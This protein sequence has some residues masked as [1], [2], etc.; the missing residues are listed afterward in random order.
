MVVKC[1][2][3]SLE[4]IKG[5]NF[6]RHFALFYI[7]A[8]LMN[9][10]RIKEALSYINYGRF[11]DMT[12]LTSTLAEKDHKQKMFELN[13][14]RITSECLTA[15]GYF[16]KAKRVCRSIEFCKLNSSEPADVKVQYRKILAEIRDATVIFDYNVLR[17]F[18]ENET[19][20]IM[21]ENFTQLLFVG[22]VCQL[23]CD[24][25]K[26]L[27]LY[28]QY[29]R[30][31]TLPLEIYH[32]IR[33]V[34]NKN[35]RFF[36]STNTKSDKSYFNTPLGRSLINTIHINL[37]NNFSGPK[38]RLKYFK[39]LFSQL[40]FEEKLAYYY[41]EYACQ[42]FSIDFED[43]LPFVEFFIRHCSSKEAKVWDIWSKYKSY[44]SNK[45]TLA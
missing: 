31:S 17:G 44:S 14:A 24:I 22:E 34:M 6:P 35:Y 21:N 3:E 40:F 8:A 15:N 39:Q 7:G 20:D 33:I 4:N 12:E 11:K 41:I 38:V 42:K 32:K 26:G 13:F 29:Y 2:H 9:L 19:L 43:V 16:K 36:M 30:W 27:Q 25:F 1:G 28:S 10:K 5:T 18:P 23:K 37:T 45:I